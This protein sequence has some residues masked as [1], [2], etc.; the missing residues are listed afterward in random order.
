MTKTID[1]K[2]YLKNIEKLKQLNKQVK[3]IEKDFGVIGEQ[4][5]FYSKFNN[6]K[7]NISEMIRMLE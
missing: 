6:I 4:F 1:K 2:T 5:Y 3:K 7:N